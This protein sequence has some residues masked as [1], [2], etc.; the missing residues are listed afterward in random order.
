[1]CIGNCLEITTFMNNVRSTFGFLLFF[2]VFRNCSCFVSKL[3]IMT[4]R[5]NTPNQ[6]ARM[7]LWNLYIY[8]LKPNF[9]SIPIIHLPVRWRKSSHASFQ[10][11]K[12]MVVV[13]TREWGHS[14]HDSRDWCRESRRNNY[15]PSHLAWNR[16]SNLVWVKPFDLALSRF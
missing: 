3:E 13:G 16:I 1:M 6:E 12:T 11:L 10:D 2:F 15:G 8:E 4:Y 5:S 7:C 9:F 14:F